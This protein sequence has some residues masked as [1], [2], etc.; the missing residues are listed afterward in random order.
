MLHFS[1]SAQ[2]L[3]F[4]T[5]HI[6]CGQH[7]PSHYC[8]FLLFSVFCLQNFPL[9]WFTY[10]KMDEASDWPGLFVKCVC[11]LGIILLSKDWNS[12][13]YIILGHPASSTLVKFVCAEL[14]LQSLYCVLVTLN[15]L[16]WVYGVYNALKVLTSL[17]LHHPC[18]APCFSLIFSRILAL[19]IALLLH[20]DNRL[21]KVAISVA[22]KWYIPNGECYKI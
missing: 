13:S 6:L 9:K 17:S 7:I 15:C 4:S 1:S 10:F 22:A 19:D 18:F 8:Y 16:F 21:N 5:C 11:T 14:Q 2:L 3:T 20:P 12:F